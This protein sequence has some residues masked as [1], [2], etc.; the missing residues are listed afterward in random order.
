MVDVETVFTDY[1]W[2]ENSRPILIVRQDRTAAALF[3]GG[4]HSLHRLPN[5]DLEA[6]TSPDL[7]SILEGYR[8]IFAAAAEWLK[9]PTNGTP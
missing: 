3:V 8:D 7:L 5:V 2:N 4:P 1:E 9:K 6:K